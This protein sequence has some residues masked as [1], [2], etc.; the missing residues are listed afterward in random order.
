VRK[1][2]LWALGLTCGMVLTGGCMSE[3]AE[4]LHIDRQIELSPGHQAE[5]YSIVHASNGDLIILG[6]NFEADSRAWATRLAPSGEVR[7]EYIQG[8]PD[9]WND[10]RPLGQRFYGAIEMPDQATLLCGN[11]VI[12]NT[13]IVWLVTIAKDGSVIT[14]KVLPPVRNNVVITL[15]SC[16]KR[17]DG[18]LLVGS[19]SGQPAGTG[20]VVKLDS[21][22]N[23][24]WTKF[25]DDFGI[26]DFI[27]IGDTLIALGWH[28]QEEYVVKIGPDGDMLAKQ[29]LPKGDGEHHLVQSTATDPKVRIVTFFSN[30]RTEIADF[31]NQLRGPT[32]TLE[33][34]N[35]GVK[36]SLG[37]PD[38]SIAIVGSMNTSYLTA[39]PSAGVTRV[40]KDGGHKS[41]AVEP[42]HQSLWYADAVLTGNG[43]DIAAVRKVGPIRSVVDFL[44]FR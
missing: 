35:V 27:D 5:P 15:Y 25:S 8:G 14:D 18:I 33:L 28:G 9:G 21:E 30:S 36:K 37:L 4:Q 7:W 31:D 41:F 10:H 42:L 32:R 26:G 12:N 44:S 17:S 3:A 29:V 2:V 22:F 34:H 6:S 38:G 13:N 39:V 11:E 40:F 24:K 23:V 16:H 20:W 43:N 1:A 19:V